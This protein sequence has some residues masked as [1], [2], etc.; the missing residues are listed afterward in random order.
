[1]GGTAVL[2]D[3]NP[4]IDY[5]NPSGSHN[6]REQSLAFPLDLAVTGDGSKVYVAAF[7]SAKVGV[8]DAAASVVN[9]IDVGSGPSGLALDESRDRLYV[10]NRFDGTVSSVDLISEQ[11]VETVGLG[12]DPLPTN[13]RDGRKLFYNAKDA[14]AHGDLSCASCHVFTASDQI[15]WDLG[16][17]LGSTQPPPPG[18]PGSSGFHPMKGP[19]FT[20]SLKGLSE[21]EPFHWRGDRRTWRRSTPH[22]FPFWAAA[23]NSGR[24]R[25]I[26]SKTSFS[27]SGIRRTRSGGSTT[28][29]PRA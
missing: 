6:E 4:H 27:P 13:L 7:G 17:P 9:R 24:P 3:L 26:C 1:M 23:R 5:G 16:N 15:S 19:M 8:L 22:S 12:F 18:Q 21:T 10:L 28:R 25:W 2:Q 20:Q 14:S 29:F 11:Q